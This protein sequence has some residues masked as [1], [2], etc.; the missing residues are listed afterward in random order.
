MYVFFYEIWIEWMSKRVELSW[1]QIK[2][3]NKK[4]DSKDLRNEEGEFWAKLIN[5]SK[6]IIY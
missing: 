5:D 2:N 6:E 1:V 4:F 3:S